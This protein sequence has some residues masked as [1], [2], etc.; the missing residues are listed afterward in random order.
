MSLLTTAAIQNLF[1]ID[2]AEIKT[3]QEILLMFL[4]SDSLDFLKYNTAT[5]IFTAITQ[6]LTIPVMANQALEALTEGLLSHLVTMVDE[7]EFMT[8][9]NQEET[10]DDYS[11]S[12][13]DIIN[14]LNHLHKIVINTYA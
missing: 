14:K 2:T 3:D 4:E 7:D 6:V 11:N 9:H 8:N 1:V 10:M 12:L 5:Q 13:H